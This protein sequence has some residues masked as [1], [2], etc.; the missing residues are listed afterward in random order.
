ML[1][2]PIKPVPPLMVGSRFTSNFSKYL[3]CRRYSREQREGSEVVVFVLRPDVVK[4]K[5]NV[6]DDFM[7]L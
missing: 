6:S 7:V 2:R 1:R 3:K 4:R 5:I